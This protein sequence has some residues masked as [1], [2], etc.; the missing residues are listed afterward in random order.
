MTAA[1][2]ESTLSRAATALRRGAAQEARQ[3]LEPLL[4]DA[5]ALGSGEEACAVEVE[6]ANALEQLG[7]YAAAMAHF[8]RA[9]DRALQLARPALR[10]RALLGMARVEH[11]LGD[12]ARAATRLDEA[13]ALAALLDDGELAGEVMHQLGMTLSRLERH[14]EA[15]RCLLRAAEHRRTCTDPAK[16]GMTLNSLGVLVLGRGNR[17]PEGSAAAR[18]AF[19][20]ARGHFESAL[21]QAQAGGDTHLQALA[22]GNIGTIA[23]SL[24][25]LQEALAHFDQQLAA[26]RSMGDRLNQS[27]ALANVGEAHRRTG[28]HG[29]ALAALQESLA[30][31][32][33]LS[34]LP[35]QRRAHSELSNTFEALGDFA[36]A[37]QHHKR[38]HVLDRRIRSDEAERQA[39]LVSARLA[40]D[41]VRRE[42]EAYRSER[43]RLRGDNARL[44]QVALTDALTELGNRR[45]FDDVMS[46]AWSAGAPEGALAMLDIDHFKRIN[47]AFGHGVG[48]RVLAE[49][50]RLLRAALRPADRAFRLGGEEFAIWLPGASP[51]AAEAVCERLRERV[52]AAPW[53]TMAT[54]LSVTASFGVAG[55]HA[56]DSAAT[57]AARADKALYAAKRGGR[58]R[59][60]SA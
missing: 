4:A 35:R 34:S 53:P 22:Q 17:E 43:D 55:V 24:G 26:L 3:L 49:I 20:T 19:A 23:G 25:E 31:G 38:F 27:L 59:V 18:A 60:H 13:A 21:A 37:L 44:T 12:A 54:D 40:V 48:D 33:A 45:E 7:D 16:L 29:P 10:A 28:Q 39:T 32:E 11:A 30:L 47:D 57:L 1:L 42:A 36:S 51:E 5:A 56:L 15:E 50:G 58:N 41:Q 6:L 52:S 2:D 14:D 46:R 8:V 9:D